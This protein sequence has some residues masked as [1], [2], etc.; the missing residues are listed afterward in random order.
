MQQRI[1]GEPGIRISF[2]YRASFWLKNVLPKRENQ[3]VFFHP[4]Q[5]KSHQMHSVGKIKCR[6]CQ[7][8][9]KQLQSSVTQSET[10]FYK[11]LIV[12]RTR[13]MFSLTPAFLFTS[14]TTFI[15]NAEH[16]RRGETQNVVGSTVKTNHTALYESHL[17]LLTKRPDNPD[18]HQTSS[19]LLFEM[20]AHLIHC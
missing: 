2:L 12:S 5:N 17:L 8:F 11:R 15:T 7:I 10:H 20:G 4:F 13:R 18:L 19:S 9:S 14:F 1:Q 3:V 6:S 16:E